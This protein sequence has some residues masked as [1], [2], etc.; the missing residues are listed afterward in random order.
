[1]VK[2]LRQPTTP[3]ILLAVISVLSL[4]ARVA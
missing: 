4:V 3:L 2:W 1:M